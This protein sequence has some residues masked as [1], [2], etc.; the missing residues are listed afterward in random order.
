MKF[1]AR[2]IEIDAFLI[3]AVGPD[4]GGDGI[5]H[6]IDLS[7]GEE[8]QRIYVDPK[9]FGNHEP[10]VGDYWIVGAEGDE[11]LC[12]KAVFENKY[13]PS[14]ETTGKIARLVGGLKF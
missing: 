3:T 9:Q 8:T 1:T 13:A 4:A 5:S 2:P 10:H 14:Q 6:A 11:Y 7:D 12:P